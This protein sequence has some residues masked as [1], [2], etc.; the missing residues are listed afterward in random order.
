[1]IKVAISFIILGF[2]LLALSGFEKIMIYLHFSDQTGR[3]M[4][5]LLLSIPK[6]IWL[7][8]NLTLISGVCLIFS[9][10]LLCLMSYLKNTKINRSK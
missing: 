5:I 4:D 1:M 6:Y 2:S 8:T 3:N 9:G 7:I 10:L